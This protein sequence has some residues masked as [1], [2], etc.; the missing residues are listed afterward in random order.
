MHPPCS[1]RAILGGLRGALVKIGATTSGSQ[2]RQSAK[3]EEVAHMLFAPGMSRFFATHPPLLERL[4]GHRSAVRRAGNRCEARAR[5]A[6]ETADAEA[7]AAASGCGERQQLACLLMR[8]RRRAAARSRSSSAIPARAHVQLAR[9]IRQVAARSESIAAG[10]ASRYG[11]RAA[12]RALALDCNAETRERQ[13]H[14]I[15][16]Q[17]GCRGCGCRSQP[18]VRPLTRSTPEQRMPVIAAHIPGA[19][20]A[21]ARRANA[22]HV[23]PQRHVAAGRA[24]VAAEPMCCANSRKCSCATT[25]IRWRACGAC[26]STP[27]R[28][29]VQVLFSVLAHHGHQD[30]AAARR[31]YEAGMHHSVP[32][33]RPAYAPAWRLGHSAGR[34]AEPSRPRRR[35]SRSSWSRRW[36]KTVTHD[37]RLTIGEAELL[38]AVCATLALPAAAAGRAVR[39]CAR[40]SARGARSRLIAVAADHRSADK[41][42]SL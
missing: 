28:S 29:D 23:V 10:R 1:S 22:A 30:D 15:A 31:A 32:R 12:A 39:R 24:H 42:D 26:R 3:V 13:K 14:F 33:E 7:Q 37:Q 2:H 36:C 19:A 25:S 40:D 8:C 4:Q 11:A 27:L 21:D 6:A 9:Q 17:L 5:V 35:S 34:R 41:Q 16:Q 20:P 38:R 18:S